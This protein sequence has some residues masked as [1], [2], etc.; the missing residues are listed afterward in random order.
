MHEKCLTVRIGSTLPL[1]NKQ[2]HFQ[3]VDLYLI[4][5]KQFITII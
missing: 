1:H 2:C 3:I 5:E 4:K